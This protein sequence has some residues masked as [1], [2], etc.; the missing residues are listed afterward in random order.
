[1]KKFLLV[2]VLAITMT[3][4][5][6]ASPDLTP[7]YGGSVN[8]V[9]FPVGEGWNPNSNNWGAHHNTLI[10]YDTLFQPDIVKAQQGYNTSPLVGNITAYRDQWIGLLVYQY[11]QPAPDHMVFYI[12]PGIKFWDRDTAPSYHESIASAYGRTLNAH[13]IIALLDQAYQTPTNTLHALRDIWEWTAKDDYT[14]E[15]KMSRGDT[16][17]SPFNRFLNIHPPPREVWEQGIDMNDWKNALGTGPFVPVEHLEGVSGRFK[18]NMDYWM[19][20]PV[21]PH[22]RLP[23][24]DEVRYIVMKDQASRLAALRSGKL[25]V[26]FGSWSIG[27]DWRDKLELE[28]TNPQLQ[29][30]EGE[31][32][33]RWFSIN[34]EKAAQDNSPWNDPR[35]RYAAMLAVDQF[36]VAENV[37]KG[38]SGGD[39][40]GFYYLSLPS[41]APYYVNYETMKKERPELAELWEY[42]PEKAKQL[43]AEAGYPDG[44]DTVA[45]LD[46]SVQ[47]WAELYQSFFNDVGIRVK[48][49]V[50]ESPWGRVPDRKHETFFNQSGTGVK[51]YDDTFGYHFWP[52]T[53]SHPICGTFDHTPQGPNIEKNLRR[54][55]GELMPKDEHVALWID[56][57]Y[58]IIEMMCHVHFPN[59]AQYTAWQ[60][61]VKNYYGIVVN[62]N[63]KTFKLVWIDEQ[64]KKEMSGR[65]P[66]E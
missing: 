2:F 10:I 47:G 40:P 15:L 4:F 1:M 57:Q 48:F 46:A 65:G 29:F 52:T 17:N 39:P 21:R 60:P 45:M 36:G 9:H 33:N 59:E 35:V 23:Y 63:Q 22:N 12:R 64:M 66:L 20:D 18:K 25:D 19:V 6:Y 31:P 42:K 38:N 61:W 56:I 54:L 55:M 14:I 62:N 28:K 41:M 8:W 32:G 24:L 58:D 43:L 37:I 11:E 13:D 51:G 34:L 50:V 27:V 49:D 7:S 53:S 3:S 26:N 30:A 44:F 5:T 16:S